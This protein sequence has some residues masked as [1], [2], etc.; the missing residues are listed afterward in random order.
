VVIGPGTRRWPFSVANAGTAGVDVLR[1]ERGQFTSADDEVAAEEPFEI[2][3]A[4]Q[5]IALVMRTPGN[6]R[7]LAAGFPHTQS[8][9][10]VGLSRRQNFTLL[11]SES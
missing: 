11:M 4:G 5:S 7:C 6:D 1:Y 2:Q 8:A 3:I 9:P 10:S